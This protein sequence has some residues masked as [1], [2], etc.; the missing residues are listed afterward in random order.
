MKRK[1]DQHMFPYVVVAPEGVHW[2][3]L[4]MDEAHAWEIALG[5][6]AEEDITECKRS[7]WYCARATLTWKNPAHSEAV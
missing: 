6:P 3:G 4:C 5:W 7:G 2:L 1:P